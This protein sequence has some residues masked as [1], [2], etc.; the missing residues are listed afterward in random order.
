MWRISRSAATVCLLPEEAGV[1]GEAQ[2]VQDD[3]GPTG[4][5][6]R[7]ADRRHLVCLALRLHERQG[8]GV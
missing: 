7:E 5:V 4:L 3:E 1:E 2:T 6:S 8:R